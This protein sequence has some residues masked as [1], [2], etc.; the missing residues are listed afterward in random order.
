MPAEDELYPDSFGCG[1]EGWRDPDEDELYPV[2]FECGKK[3][4]H[5]SIV[6]GRCPR[7]AIAMPEFRLEVSFGKSSS[8][9]YRTALRRAREI[10]T[11]EK[12]KEGGKDRHFVRFD[13]LGEYCDCRHAVD[14]LS[15]VIFCWV[16]S[17]F[18]LN[19]AEITY[20][21]LYAISCE[22]DRMRDLEKANRIEFD[23]GG[24]AVYTPKPPLE[25]DEPDV[26]C[27]SS[28]HDPDEAGFGDLPCP[29]KSEEQ[30]RQEEYAKMQDIRKPLSER[31]ALG[32]PFVQFCAGAG[33]CRA[34]EYQR[35]KKMRIEDAIE[36]E[37]LYGDGCP[38]QWK[39]IVLSEGETPRNGVLTV[40]EMARAGAPHGQMLAN[41]VYWKIGA[42]T[43]EQLSMLY[44][45]L[46]LSDK[47]LSEEHEIAYVYRVLGDINL[48]LGDKAGA[49]CDYR[50]A[51]SY[52]S[53]AGVKKKIKELEKGA[54][55][56][57]KS[58][59][60]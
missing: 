4:W 24:N 50:T 26:A 5:S 7:C 1:E 49:L 60:E 21:G 22:I 23:G 52:S 3:E 54:E 45:G 47:T 14:R 34:C 42:A 43:P 58:G 9:K 41:E 36:Y 28:A 2:C 38:C 15:L 51:L 27:L 8:K 11:Y 48:A 35:G 56:D 53:G 12:E 25:P 18:L 33:C 10:P 46:F 30:T 57:Q 55:H 13:N 29:P 31:Q 32:V 19:G 17:R 6:L 59:T 44:E 39:S 16:S 40:E 20:D 37:R